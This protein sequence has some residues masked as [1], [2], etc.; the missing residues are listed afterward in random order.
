LADIC[1]ENEY[2]IRRLYAAHQKHSN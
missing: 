1:W 2:I